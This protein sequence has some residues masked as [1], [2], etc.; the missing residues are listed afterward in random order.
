[1][2]L[3]SPD[4]KMEFEKNLPESQFDFVELV[5]PRDPSL[6]PIDPRTELPESSSDRGAWFGQTCNTAQKRKL[7]CD[8]LV[9]STHF[10]G[11]LERF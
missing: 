1:M 10:G 11:L 3:N 2:T 4:E 8:A 5:H 9:I 6:G 7:Q